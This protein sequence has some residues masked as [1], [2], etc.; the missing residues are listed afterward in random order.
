MRGI[1]YVALIAKL[2][3]KVERISR[4]DPEI[5]EQQQKRII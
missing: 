3:A 5:M 2:P 4:V 1:N